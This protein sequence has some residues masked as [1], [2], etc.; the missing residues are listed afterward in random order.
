MKAFPLIIVTPDG[1]AYEGEVESLL[2]RTDDGD[3]EILA[4]HADYLAS[5]AIGRTRI[6]VGGIDRFASS[7]G[8]FLT[9]KGGEAKLVLTTF[10]FADEIDKKRAELAREK[11]EEAIAKA[12]SSRDI[13]V[14]KAKLR[15]ALNRLSVV[16]MK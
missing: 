14:A 1:L 11:A 8:G 12:K 5:V 9:V 4:G 13:D 15:R 6:R 16:G 2:C 3:V 7:S 10:E